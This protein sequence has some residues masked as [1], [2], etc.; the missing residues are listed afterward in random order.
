MRVVYSPTHLLHDPES[1]LVSGERVPAWEVTGRGEAI[2][3]ALAADP[4][5]AIGA[6]Q[7]HGLDPILAV[8]DSGLVRLL[9]R[10]WSD[11]RASGGR[12]RELSPDTFPIPGIR[13]ASATRREPGSIGGRLGAWCFDTATPI[14]AGTWPPPGLRRMSP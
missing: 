1:E 5:F 7:E 12:A 9:E 2:R 10:A 4:A 14:T 13:P 6:P 11:W 8:H 3:A